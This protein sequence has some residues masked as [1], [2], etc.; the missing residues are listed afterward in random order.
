[1][2]GAAHIANMSDPQIPA[3]LAPVVIGVVSLN[4]F[5]PHAMNHPRTSYTFSSCDDVTSGNCYAVVPADLATIYNLNPLFAAGYSG[6]GQTIV[7]LEDTDLYNK[8]NS[9]WNTFRS[10]F[11]LASAYPNGSLSSVHPGNCQDPGVNDADSEAA[12]DVEW[13]SAAAPNAAIEMA[14]CADTATTFGGFI[15]LANLLNESDTPPAIVSISYGESEAELGASQNKYINGLYQQAVTEGVSVFVSAGDSGAASS[16]SQTAKA[17]THGIAVSGFAS[18]PYN[19]AMGGTDFGDT[20]ANAT[21]TYWSN[22]NGATYGSALSYVPEI[23]WNDTCASGLIASY[24][25]FPSTYGSS[26]LCNADEG[27]E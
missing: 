3:A 6:Q 17:A 22:S 8:S 19:V 5:R 24:L 27:L 9:D 4:D 10:V 11:G 23:P 26:S 15:A 1:M 12:I 21:S 7:V 18:T 20:Y 2:N 14:S 16:E 25:D 13:S